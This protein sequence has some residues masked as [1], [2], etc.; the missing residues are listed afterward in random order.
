MIGA[1][2]PPSGGDYGRGWEDTFIHIFIANLVSR[3]ILVSAATLNPAVL[4]NFAVEMN[5]RSLIRSLRRRV[6]GIAPFD[7]EIMRREWDERAKENARYYVATGKEQWTDEEFFQ[8]GSIWV[9]DYIRQDLSSICRRLP[10]QSMHILEIGCG[11]GRMTVPLCKMF[12]RVDAVDVS[13]AMAAQARV[14]LK[15]C[16]NAAV[17]VNN[18]MDLSGFPD[19]QFDFVFSGIVFQHIPRKSIVESYIRES[20]R[21]L[22]PNSIFKFQVQGSAIDEAAANTWVGVGFSEDE[23]QRIAARYQF[24]ILQTQG[25]GTQYYW[26]TFLKP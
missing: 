4:Y 23:M 20:W 15:D 10:A 9:D 26:L 14:A 24:Q 12:G 25:A 11:A 16:G 3:E 18:G 19:E 8:S 6:R 17:H 5:L 21:V 22:R 2:A 7:H 1:A 13:P